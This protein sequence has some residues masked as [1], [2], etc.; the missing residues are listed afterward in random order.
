[1]VPRESDVVESEVS[2]EVSVSP[3]CPKMA[4]ASASE[5]VSPRRAPSKVPQASTRESRLVVMSGSTLPWKVAAV[6]RIVSEAECAA[7]SSALA[8]VS[9][10]SAV[11]A[12]SSEAVRRASVVESSW[13]AS[14]EAASEE[15]ASLEAAE[16]ETAELA[17]P[18]Q[19]ARHSARLNASSSDTNFFMMSSFFPQ[20]CRSPHGN[21]CRP[22]NAKFYKANLQKYL[23]CAS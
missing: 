21:R 2:E 11:E 17:L 14:L 5:G 12:R 20:G 6:A 1:M 22:C 10:E 16:P 3:S 18:P 13:A 8:S 4:R 23:L 9:R 19:A 7:V 15:A